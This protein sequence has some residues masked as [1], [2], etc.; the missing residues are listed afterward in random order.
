MLDEIELAQAIREIVKSFQSND[1][2]NTSPVVLK[3]HTEE[4]RINEKRFH[5]LLVKLASL[6]R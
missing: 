2:D 3:T 1:N 5:H 6:S 4:F